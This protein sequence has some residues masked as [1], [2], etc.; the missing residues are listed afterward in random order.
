MLTKII[1]KISNYK[2]K[3]TEFFEFKGANYMKDLERR[4]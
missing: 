4:K 3:K 2:R 1:D